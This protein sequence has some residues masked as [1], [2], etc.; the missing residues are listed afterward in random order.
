MYLHLISALLWRLVN[1]RGDLGLQFLQHV[2]VISS[3]SRDIRLI[4]QLV[5][6]IGHLTRR[7]LHDNGDN[8]LDDNE[9]SIDV[10]LHHLL[11]DVDMALYHLL[12]VIDVLLDATSDD[13][14]TVLRDD[15]DDDMHQLRNYRLQYRQTSLALRDDRL[16]VSRHYGA[17]INT[18]RLVTRIVSI[19]V[20][21]LAKC[22]RARCNSRG[23]REAGG[24]F[25]RSV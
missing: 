5:R 7:H 12:N 16:I 22:S 8:H 1:C 4:W 17:Y 9:L 13:V 3:V 11:D 25:R 18:T 15:I 2:I 19:V 20:M 6:D 21:I 24:S 23:R 14:G 10:I